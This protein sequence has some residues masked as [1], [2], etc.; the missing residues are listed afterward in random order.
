MGGDV[1]YV[2]PFPVG[3]DFAHIHTT[4]VE[5]VAHIITVTSHECHGVSN[6]SFVK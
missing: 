6:S 2:T 1:I 5:M 4:G 3:K